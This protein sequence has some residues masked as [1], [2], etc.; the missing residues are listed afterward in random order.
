M[1]SKSQFYNEDNLEEIDDELE[2]SELP[3]MG[4]EDGELASENDGAAFE[5]GAEKFGSEEEI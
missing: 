4:E 3:E 1:T 2:D 5:D